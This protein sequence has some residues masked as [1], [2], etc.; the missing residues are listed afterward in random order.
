MI[1]A[2]ILFAILFI[3]SLANGQTIIKGLLKSKEDGKGMPGINVSI[4]DKKSTAM[5][6]YAITNDKG[7]YSLN[8]T[9]SADSLLL[10]I[11]GF[12]IEKQTH[13]LA[14][15]SSEQNFEVNNQAIKL[16]EIKVNPP[17]IRKL[18]DT[19]NYLVDGFKDKNDRT[20]GDVLKKMPGIE[21]KEDGSILY[22]NRPINKFYIED[23]DLLQGR[24]GIATNNIE[25]KDVATVQVLENHQPVKAL[26]NREFSDD[27]ALNIKLKDGAKG[28]LVANAKVGAGRS[29]LLWNNELFSMYF[30]KGRQ[31]LNTYKGNNSGDDPGADLSSYYS[32]ANRYTGSTSLAVQSPSAPAISQKRYLFNRA[33]AFTVNNLWTAG[34]DNQINANFSYLDDRQEKSSFSRSVYYLPADSMLTIQ[35][36]LASTET[37]HQLDASLQLNKNKEN[38][39]LDNVFN[40]KGKWNQSNA[41]AINQDTVFQSLRS[42]FYAVNNTLS[43]IRNYK[44]TSLNVY[45]YNGYTRVPQ[46]LN[47]QPVLYGYLFSGLSNP[48]SMAQNLTQNQFVS[49]SRVS[50]GL[51]KGV[52]K[53]NYAMGLNASIKRFQSELQEKTTSGNL[54][55]P[56][57]SLSNNLGWKHYEL[58]FNPDYTYAKNQVKVLFSLPLSYNYLQTDDQLSGN[59]K[60]LNRLFFEPSLS[61]NYDFNLFLALVA[62]ARYDNELGEIGNVFTGYIMQSYRSLV[63]NDGQL[64]EQKSQTYSLDL[65][66]RHPIKALF[67]NFGTKYARN[68]NN[69]LYGY[70]Y[71]GI[72]SLKKT[73][74]IPNTTA[75]YSAYAKISKG[76]DAIGGTVTLDASFNSSQATTISQDQLIEF[77]NERYLLK[78]AVNAKIGTWASFYYSFQ[79]SKSKNTVRNDL[80]NFVPL[81]N[82]TQRSQVNFYPFTGF[83]INLT[84]EYFYSSAITSGNR[85]MNFA[86]TGLKYRNKNMEYGINYNNIF[87]VKQYISASYNSTN[88]YYSAYNL[89]PAQVMLSVRFKVK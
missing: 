89:R 49:N 26:K 64:P 74:N 30:N 17:K 52:W 57:D 9:S 19:I 27:A 65:N 81:R 62:S 50:F 6:T 1:R 32:D 48:V 80:S 69:Q 38:Y 40:F 21:V 56:I 18:N 4:K 88:T 10:I 55:S 68:E 84:H 47:V 76:I 41:T 71:Q 35:E 70:D 66:Y 87:N 43:L 54:S 29:P 7:I 75:V 46:D 45:S 36:N 77:R 60:S 78:P 5:L 22:N 83:A 63:R 20:I 61:V 72:L 79:F 23:R 37:V 2:F 59:N 73:Y 44:K 3:T 8:V 42:P 25:A 51:T 11:A 82:N 16:K 13:T 39:Y 86:D 15:H 33:H 31:N 12:N 85:T 58:Y 28:V 67:I 24:Y 53:Q 14:N 34:K